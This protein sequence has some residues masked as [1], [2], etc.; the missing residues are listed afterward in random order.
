ML[1][2]F[3]SLFSKSIEA[4]GKYPAT[5][6]FGLLVLLFGVIALGH[7]LRTPDE[8]NQN[9]A[10]ETKETSVFDTREDTAFI[11]VPAKVKKESVVHIVALVPGVVS[12][13][14]TS[15]GRNVVSGQTLITL[16]NDYQSGSTELGKRLAEESARL[17]A[18]L[19]AIDKD[20]FA[21]EEKKTRHDSSITDTEQDIA[22]GELKKDRATR[23]STLEQNALSLQMSTVSDAVLKPKTFASGIVQSIT[24]KRGDLVSAG[25]VIATI[26]AT[27]GATTIETFLDPKTARIFDATK[28]AKLQIGDEVIM[29]R[30][31]YFAQSENENGLFSVL[32]TL[33][34]DLESKITNGEFLKIALPLEKD[35]EA[36]AL[37]PIDAIFQDDK[38]AWV[39]VERDGKAVSVAVTLGNLYGSFA[40]IR[41][42]LTTGD[43]IIL[44]RAILS[45]D[46]V[47]LVK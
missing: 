11:T 47:T 5:S 40:E 44:S 20:I 4:L 16:T 10:V 13:I 35:A 1:E 2:R 28:E 21:L 3:K 30:P 45:G 7:F 17:T 27:R 36:L 29:L 37:V 22:L 14:L 38:D 31:T 19:A 25:Q 26:R 39:L 34:Q 12:N 15:P 9:A 42:G 23:R 18:E 43:R 6:F 46:D 24:V 41:S 32:F 8:T 33:S